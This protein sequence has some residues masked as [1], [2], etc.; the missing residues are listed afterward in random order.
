MIIISL[1]TTSTAGRQANT[2][3]RLLGKFFSTYNG[4]IEFCEKE[5]DEPLTADDVFNVLHSQYSNQK[6][7]VVKYSKNKSQNFFLNI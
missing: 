4:A 6:K 1:K 3:P 5:S 2:N 7:S